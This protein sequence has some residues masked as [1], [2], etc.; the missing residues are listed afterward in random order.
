LPLIPRESLINYFTNLQPIA[1]QEVGLWRFSNGADYYTHLLRHY[2]TTESTAED[3]HQLGLEYVVRIQAEMRE[4]FGQL[5]Y[6]FSEGYVSGDSAEAAF[7]VAIDQAIGMLDQA[8]DTPLKDQIVVRG[9][10]T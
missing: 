10:V 1:P 3:I 5:G 6:S 4:A 8:F 7:Q 9:S 2:T